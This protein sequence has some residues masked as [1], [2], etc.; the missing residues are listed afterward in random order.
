M[1]QIQSA[2]RWPGRKLALAAV[3]GFIALMA[4]FQPTPASA[5]EAKYYL[6]CP[7]TEVR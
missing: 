6:D 5:D 2:L 7:T 4:F 1:K 3:A